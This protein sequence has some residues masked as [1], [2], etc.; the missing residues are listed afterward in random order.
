MALADERTYPK[1]YAVDFDGTL[2]ERAWPEIGAPKWR[3]IDLVKLL[4]RQGDK[5]ILWTN[6]SGE[7]LAKAIIWCAEHGLEFDAVNANLPEEIERWN[8]DPRKIGADAYI[9]DKAVNALDIE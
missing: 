9:D 1:V 3:I 7:S 6:R 2:C 4:R 8:S 5:I